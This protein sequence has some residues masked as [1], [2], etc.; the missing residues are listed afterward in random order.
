M[1][2][3]RESLGQTRWGTASV[4]LFTFTPDCAGY[5]AAP[6]PPNKLEI[7]RLHLS[8]TTSVYPNMN[9][10]GTTRD[11]RGRIACV[12]ILILL[13]NFSCEKI[14]TIFN[15]NLPSASLSFQKT[16]ASLS[17]RTLYET[18]PPRSEPTPRGGRARYYGSWKD[19]SNKGG[20]RGGSSIAYGRMKERG[21]P[22]TVCLLVANTCL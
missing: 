19:T 8:L 4:L 13:N 21:G 1:P 16:A 2:S 10:P 6:G 11:P 12:R 3:S 14:L 18:H 17:S 22:A 20:G 15:T 9:T 7:N 5:M